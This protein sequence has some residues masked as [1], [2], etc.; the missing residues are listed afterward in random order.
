M[1]RGLFITGTDTGVGKTWITAGLLAALR[2]QGLRACGMKP[3]ATGC[4][5]TPHGLRNEDALR[6]QGESASPASPYELINRYAFAPA[7]SPHLAAQMTGEHI[8][9]ALIRAD[10]RQLAGQ[11]DYV[12]VE[13]VGGWHTPINEDETIADLARVLDLPVVLVVGIR[14]GCINHALL[15]SDAIEESGIA[16]AGWIANVVSPD[17]ALIEGNIDT[18][19]GHIAA[20]LLG[21]VPSLPAFDAERIGGFLETR[22]LCAGMF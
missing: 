20:P 14:L 4:M 6:L 15:S 1:N 8:D 9:T 3:I 10:L 19:R 18:L 13:G 17:M 21:T 2:A 11:S 5:A 7:A 16:L 22:P 12:L